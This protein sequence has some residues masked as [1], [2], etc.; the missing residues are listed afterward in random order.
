MLAWLGVQYGV[1]KHLLA[2]GVLRDAAGEVRPY[3]IREGGRIRAVS[4][5]PG[6]NS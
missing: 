2:G 1:V 4:R 3:A 5:Q 6:A